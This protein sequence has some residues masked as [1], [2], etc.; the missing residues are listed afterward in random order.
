MCHVKKCRKVRREAKWA[1]GRRGDIN[2]ENGGRSTIK[3]GPKAI[4][5]C[6]LI[7]RGDKVGGIKVDKGEIALN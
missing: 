6:C 7:P 5:L 3:V 1:G 4:N 2:V